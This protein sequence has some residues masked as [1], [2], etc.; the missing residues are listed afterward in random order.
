MAGFSVNA[1]LGSVAE[2]TRCTCADWR[3][4][5]E[6]TTPVREAGTTCGRRLS[7]VSPGTDRREVLGLH[8]VLG[9]SRLRGAVALSGGMPDVLAAPRVRQR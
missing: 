9:E 1:G 5:L 6:G 4:S 3:C 2:Q 7:G 8:K